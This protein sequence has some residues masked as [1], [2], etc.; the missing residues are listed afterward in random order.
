M[1]EPIRC[2][3]PSVSE[4]VDALN[5]LEPLRIDFRGD[6]FL[7]LIRHYN[8]VMKLAEAL[9][10][11]ADTRKRLASLVARARRYAFV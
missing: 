7:F 2:R 8:R 5:N 11:R 10:L 9:L 3:E 4:V 6:V 1:A